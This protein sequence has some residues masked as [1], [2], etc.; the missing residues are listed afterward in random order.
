M[1]KDFL[2]EEVI[3]GVDG[4]AY[5]QYHITNLLYPFYISYH[6]HNEIEVIY[7]KKGML[8]VIIDDTEYMGNE[9]DVFLVN[10]GQIHMMSTK[11]LTTEYYTLLFD[12]K[13]IEFEQKDEVNDYFKAINEEELRLI[14]CI[15]QHVSYEKIR[16][17]IEEIISMNIMKNKLYKFD[18]K[19]K[20]LQILRLLLGNSYMLAEDRRYEG[21]NKE[22]KRLILTYIEENYNSRITLTDVANIA[23]M[24][25]KYFSRFFKENFGINFI[26]YITR[27]R[28]EKAAI[29]L[30]TTDNS[31]TDIAL[32][33]GYT[34]ISYFIRS[35][36][37]SFEVSPHKF[38]TTKR[39]IFED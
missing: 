15:R 20:I 35:F 16:R 9:G 33:C 1:K 17:Y 7:I 21:K 4:Y 3:H 13:L 28:L 12:I 31:V 39:E 2:K 27:V 10:P 24:S 32:K 11:D 30:R 8:K 26:D 38:R 6:W 23:H 29:L 5:A 14:T 25:E 37:K 18:T 34:N 22:I 36:K 19:V